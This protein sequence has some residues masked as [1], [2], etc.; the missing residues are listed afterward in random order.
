MHGKKHS[1]I[2]AISF[3]E[4]LIIVL[5]I[6]VLTAIA[7]P[8]YSIYVI[9]SKSSQMLRDI[10]DLKTAI[11]DYRTLNK[12]FAT[13]KNGEKIKEIYEIEDPTEFS[14]VIDKIE[15]RTNSNDKVVIKVLATG[16]SLSLRE[17]KSLELILNGK[18][19]EEGIEWI[20]TSKGQ[21]KY[22]PFKCKNKKND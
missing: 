5:I 2:K 7:I 13:A 22:A 10:R 11:G 1:K 3:F 16:S 20:C 8:A 21:T 19:S 15:V 18:W 14:E 4:F 17:G 9:R 6:G 12:K